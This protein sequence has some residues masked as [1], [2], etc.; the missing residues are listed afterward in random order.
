MSAQ[1]RNAVVRHIDDALCSLQ[2]AARRI[3]KARLGI[4]RGHRPPSESAEMLQVP[5]DAMDILVTGSAACLHE[6]VSLAK[7]LA[8]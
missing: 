2:F 8:A 7:D 5:F 4:V 3:A 6:A 1:A